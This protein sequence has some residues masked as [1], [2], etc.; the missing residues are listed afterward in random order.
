MSVGSAVLPRKKG[1]L[2]ILKSGS[3]SESYICTPPIHTH[4]Q[5]YMSAVRV[6]GQSCFLDHPMY[7]TICFNFIPLIMFYSIDFFKSLRKDLINDK[8][9]YY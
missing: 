3:Y 4:V 1:Q 9:F 6:C 5:I 2:T 7:Q 8:I